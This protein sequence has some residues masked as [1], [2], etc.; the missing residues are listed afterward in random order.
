M[1]TLARTFQVGIS[2]ALVTWL[3]ACA[4]PPLQ[5]DSQAVEDLIVQ[6]AVEEVAPEFQ[7]D[8][9]A[10][11]SLLKAGEYDKAIVLLHKVTEIMKDN[12]VPYINLA[13]AYS[14]IGNSDRAEE[15]YKAALKIDPENPVANNEYALF[16]R[17]LGR[18]SEARQMYEQVLQ[19]YP[20]FNLARKNLGILC[21]LYL[22]DYECAL[23]QYTLYN[24]AVPEDKTVKIWIADMQ[25]RVVQ[26]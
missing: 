26:K 21:D 5:P 8:F 10:A 3:A 4:S 11:L 17:N 13:M 2:L 19:K 24:S 16:K 6:P 9:D 20:R 18:F 25:K 15:N 1:K 23:K 14:K 12:V 7:A 22:R